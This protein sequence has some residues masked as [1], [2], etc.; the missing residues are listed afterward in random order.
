MSKKALHPQLDNKRIEN[1]Y[2]Q[3]K[4]DF[5]KVLNGEQSGLSKHH[6]AL[7]LLLINEVPALRENENRWSNTEDVV[8]KSER[9]NRIEALLGTD[10]WDH[11]DNYGL[12]IYFFG[13]ERA[14]YARYA[15]TRIQFQMYQTG[16]GRRSFS[17]PGNREM[18]LGNQINFLINLIPQS[19]VFKYG[20]NYEVT[21]T[22][23]NLTIVE[24]IRYDFTI[25]DA[26]STLFRL[27]SAAIDLDN[28]EV[29][30][31]LEAIVFNTDT[32]GKVTGRIIKALMGSN[33]EEAWVLVE[34]LLLAAQRQEGL[35]QTILEPLDETSTGGLIHILRVILMHKLS[36]FSSVV[37]AIGVWAGLG[38]ESE[39]EATVNTFL[40]KALLYL[41]KP[42]E[43]VNGI[44]SENNADV[45]MALWAQGVYDVEQTLPYLEELLATGNVEKRTL[46]LIFA[47][48][49]GHYAIKMPLY[50]KALDDADIQ[51]LTCAVNFANESIHEND[52][53]EYYNTH[54]PALFDKLHDVYRRITIKEKTFEG[55][56]FSWM[57]I[58]F[59]RKNMLRAMIPLILDKQ[60]RLDILL[61][62]FEDMDSGLKRRLTTIILPEQSAYMYKVTDDT[63]PLTP[64]QRRYAML[65]LKDRSEFEIAVKALY[66]VPFEL[67]EATV[68]S[69]LLKRKS[70][71]FR[72][73]IIELLIRQNDQI[74]A[75]VMAEVLQGDVEQRLAGLDILLQLQKEKRL[76]A[77]SKDLVAAFKERKNIS[78]KEEILLSQ[79]TGEA[80]QTVI[81]EEN[82]YGLYNPANCA[83]VIP[84][85]IDPASL[86]EQLLTEN[87]YGFSL[88]F[89]EITKALKALKKLFD[90]HQHHEYEV[91]YADVRNTMLLGNYFWRKHPH[92]TSF[93]TAQEEYEDYPLHEVWEAWYQQW[94]LQ[95]RDL[96]ILALAAVR[97]DGEDV[98]TEN[99]LLPDYDI[100]IHDNNQ[101][102]DDNIIQILKALEIIHPYEKSNEFCIAATKRLFSGLDDKTLQAKESGGYMNYM[103]G[104]Q[105]NEKLNAFLRRIDIDKLETREQLIDYW[106]L[107][108]WHQ[109]SGRPENVS[110]NVP[111]LLLFCTTFREG[112]I[113]RD[114]MYRGI[115]TSSNI[116]DL[117][118]QIQKADPDN[119]VVKFPFL[120]EML[121]VVFNQ[122]LDVELK[123]GDSPTPLTPFAAGLNIIFGINRFTEIIAGLGKTALYKGY[124]YGDG[125]ESK[126]QLFCMLLKN[127]YPLSTDT[128]EL[129]NASMQQIKATEQRLIEAAVYAPQWQ[130]F[131]SSYLGW[132]GLD[133]AI[134][135]MHAHTKTTGYNVIDAATESEIAKYSSIDVEYFKDGAVDKDWFLKTYAEIGRE[136]WS[137]VY[138]A[139]KYIS[140]GNGHRRARTYADVL[141][142]V[143]S[144]EE[145]IEKIT[146]K[147]DQDYLRIYGLA[148]FKNI[149]R[150]VLSRYEYLQQ[151]KKESRQFGAQ[152]Q[153][154]EGIAIAVAMD[155]LARNAGYADPVRLTWAMEITQLQQIFSKETAVQYDDVIIRLVIDEKGEADV[156][157]F[158]NDAAQKAIPAKYKKDKKVEELNGYK[159]TL[160][161]QLSR[162]RKGLEDAMVRGD[163]FLLSE[164]ETLFTHPV[165]SKHLQKLIFVTDDATGFYKDG[166]LTDADGKETALNDKSSIR[167]AHSTDLHKTGVWASYQRYAFDHTLEQPFKQIFR[168]LYLPTTD[169][170]Q[171]KSVSRRY[172]GHQIQPR[173]TVALLKSKG[174]KVNYEEGLQK[175]FHKEGFAVKMYAM[176]DWFTPAEVEHPTLE[177]VEFHDL[178]TFAKIEFSTIHPRIF[179]EAMRDIDLV[180]SVAH[181]GG[182]DAEASH[183]SIEMRTALLRETM[184]LFKITN[185]EIVGSHVI[186]KGQLGEYNV[187]I[188]SAVVHKMA[189]GY[190]SILPVHSQQRGRLFLPFVDDDPKSAE[191]ISKVLLLAR[192]HEIQD[193]TILSQLK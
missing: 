35:R 44:S 85:V 123:R 158:K 29:L 154:S 78:T 51:P 76:V 155:N 1:P 161:E 110:L 91:S 187:H 186:I 32:E 175:V 179:S 26:H 102:P 107:Y 73:S 112:I 50:F 157:A 39:R 136:R 77:A 45:Y 188:G 137:V 142:G 87:E 41:E 42:E 165:I 22:Y 36:R 111:H 120:K 11:E 183:S 193:P 9:Y 171:E 2:L 181:A 25:D 170:L 13:E 126:P 152:K 56:V 90:K 95:P 192:D 145:I 21:Y 72:S 178:K 130:K 100:F 68:F 75:V 65:I 99:K 168:E 15:W 134:W 5:E 86:Y 117:T 20:A 79:L 31:Q 33:K 97:D 96:L 185:T 53:G 23:Y 38:W 12:L 94:H 47:R 106:N 141:L 3:Y 163:V 176:A 153:S 89:S 119:Y 103:G 159:K 189:S 133:T 30:Q 144:T 52:Y 83:P 4:T 143:L 114:D 146:T 74:V 173:Q 124:S 49:T 104:W 46:A 129:F 18:Y 16:T 59:D 191:L 28:T 70:G 55:V 93:A 190:L 80:Q 92:E 115:M 135:W 164:M 82:G 125:R 88:P 113:G 109:Y 162:S 160:R 17:S 151:F 63:D 122:I 169:E 84:P 54:Y 57:K 139:A 61:S 138:D 148:P 105:G 167:I 174:W 180:V 156:V 177:T 98:P 182:V 147:R 27:W 131:I 6:A 7:G 43:I 71:T 81:S 150:D 172:A 118:Y 8:Y 69:Q 101:Y 60:E 37:R 127:C 166:K 132:K 14:V 116:R 48:E 10:A 108:N 121:D 184:R 67:S 24:Q 19:R 40:E 66:P 64:F 149:E 34:K 140:D 62:Y 128:Q 58:S